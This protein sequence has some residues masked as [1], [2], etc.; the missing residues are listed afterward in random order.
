MAWIN[1][2]GPAAIL[3]RP[4]EHASVRRFGDRPT[5]GAGRDAWP[6]HGL[7]VRRRLFAEP[8]EYLGVGWHG[9]RKRNA[10]RSGRCREGR[11]K[12]AVAASRQRQ[13]ERAVVRAVVR[14]LSRVRIHARGE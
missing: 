10:E 1:V 9:R 14:N 11:A 13:H 7:M 5:G 2:A 12:V 3:P 4:R 8:R 6:G